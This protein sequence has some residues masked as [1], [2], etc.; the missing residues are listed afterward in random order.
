[1]AIHN[2]FRNSNLSNSQIIIGDGNTV[3]AWNVNNGKE[4]NEL[5]DIIKI[6]T[7]NMYALDEKDIDELLDIV[8]MVKEEFEKPKPK[9]GR[10]RNCLSLLAPMVTVANGIPVLA[11]NLQKLMDYISSYLR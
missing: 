6:I 1:M 3:N 4:I 11:C 8:E 5:A 7:E 2:T 9:E 10:L